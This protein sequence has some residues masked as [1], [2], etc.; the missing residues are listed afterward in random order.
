MILNLVPRVSLFPF[1]WS[2]REE[3]EAEKRAPGNKVGMISFF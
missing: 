1:S 2:R 3:G